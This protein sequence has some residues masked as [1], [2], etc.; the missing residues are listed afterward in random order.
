MRQSWFAIL[1]WGA[2]ACGTAAAPDPDPTPVT[3]DAF[4]SAVAQV[5]DDTG[6]PGAGIALVRQDGI[7]W[8]GGVGLADREAG[9][10]VT[11]DTGFRVGSISKTFIALALVQLSEDG[12]V[13]LDAPIEEIA[14]EITIDNPW[15]DTDPVR[16]IHVLEHTAGFDDM[17]FSEMYVPPGLDVPSLEEVIR[18][19]PDSRRVRW[20]PGT[21]MAY[22]NPGYGLAGR[23]LEIASGE[24]FEDYLARDVFE[25][26]EMTRSAFR[27]TPEDLG[28]LAQGYSGSGGP[29]GYP[30]IYLRPAGG[31]H[32]TPHDLGRFVQALLGW[33][34]LGGTAVI[35]PEYLGSMEQPRSSLA[36]SRGLRTG[37][38][39]GIASILDL[40]YPML[41]HGGGI[42]GFVSMLAYSPSRDVG[43]VVLLN[44]DT[45]A[46]DRALRRI[47][48]LALT[49]LKRDVEPPARPE[50]SVP[51]ATLDRYAGYYH[52]ASPRNQLLWPIESL[53]AGQTIARDGSVLT[54]RGVFGPATRLIPVTETLVRRERETV[55]SLVFVEDD[56]GQ[57]VLTGGSTY[58]VRQPRWRVEVVRVPV[59]A[60][61]AVVLS[62]PVV[63]LAWLVHARRAAPRGFWVLKAAMLASSAALLTPVLVMRATPM[64]LW[65]TQTPATQLL[66]V[67]S[68]A[69]PALGVLAAGLAWNARRDRASAAL[70]TYA[71]IVAMAAI[72]VSVYLGSYGLLGLRTWAY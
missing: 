19:H 4:R 12:W 47:S 52:P 69:L 7:E 53:F 40:P 5:L 35:D 50:A 62:V 18:Q 26:L 33:G 22:S 10:P 32:S 71:W 64:T 49:Y 29:V 43:F 16:L 44:S 42:A 41:G 17:H 24:P 70:T 8:E 48:R 20:R 25:R 30:S 55:A 27:V 34:E 13:D 57:L 28:H 9:T 54:A 2:A 51:A 59:L 68:V 56:A 11:A 3:L 46:A 72:I 23:L 38:A 1:V 31:L 37:Y 6:V 63:A 39:A 66:Y 15:S 58:A 67:A 36:A 65:G 14:P 60:S 61:I 45:G 21:R